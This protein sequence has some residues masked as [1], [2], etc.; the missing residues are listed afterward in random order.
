MPKHGTQ[1][2]KDARDLF[3]EYYNYTEDMEYCK[4]INFDEEENIGPDK[5]IKKCEVVKRLEHIK[6]IL[7][8]IVLDEDYYEYDDADYKYMIFDMGEYHINDGH[9]YG[10]RSWILEF[11]IDEYYNL[12][13]EKLKGYNILV[14]YI[15]EKKLR[16]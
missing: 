13:E 4:S 12:I 14:K 10:Y 11:E 8:E 5:K 9:G 15:E 3:D 6:K 16:M 7:E 2:Q 1:L